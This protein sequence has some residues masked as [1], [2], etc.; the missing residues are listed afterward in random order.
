MWAVPVAAGAAMLVGLLGTLLPFLPGIP[1]I[2]AAGVV[3]A[4]LVGA[5]AT[6]WAA[7]GVMLVIGAAGMVVGTL[8]PAKTTAASG[9]PRWV[10]AAAALGVVV[11][12]FVIPVVGALVG[13]PVAVF[14]AELWRL[15]DVA[16]ASR[17]TRAALR[18]MGLGIAIQFGA[19]L[20]MILVWV[21]ALVVV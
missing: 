5:G 1:L 10:L 9:A 7:V 8:L 3:W 4:L 13:G 14:L 17:S 11:G 2:M 18:G 6:G 15:R 12:F 16:Q 21:A 19:A 20:A